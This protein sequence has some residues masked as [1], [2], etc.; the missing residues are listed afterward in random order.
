MQQILEMLIEMKADRIA[1]QEKADANRKADQE[2][3]DT[4]RQA[5]RELL[6]GIMDANVKSMREDIRCGQ[7][8][9]RSILD[10]WI[11]DIKDARIKTT[12]CQEV[13]GANPEK[14]EPNPG[15]MQS[16]EE[17][18]EIPKEDAAVMPVGELRK[19][20]RDRNLAAGRRQK[21]KRR[22]QVTC[23]SWRRLIVSGKKITRRATVAWRKRRVFRRTVSQENC[24][25]R[26][27]LT[28]KQ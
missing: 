7:A 15:K 16:A 20:R 9:M 5:D 14:I 1:D 24:G 23:E 17:H 21:P 26:S 6:K 13:T 22:I 19:R 10:A 3:A 27:T 25:P 8:E 4:N 18:Q 2:K 11:T 28:G 12:A